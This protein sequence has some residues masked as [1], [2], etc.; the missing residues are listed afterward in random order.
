MS[1][2][3]SD[4]S[5]GF[6]V[7]VTGPD[8]V[9]LQMQQLLPEVRAALE[10]VIRKSADQ[11]LGEA[12][13]LASGD[14]VQ[15]RSGRYLASLESRV[16]STPDSVFGYVWSD[17]PGLAAVF[18]FGG[19]QA[20]REILPNVAQALRFMGTTGMVF[21]EIVHRPSVTYEAK[22]IIH[23]AFDDQMTAVETQIGDALVTG[24]ERSGLGHD[25]QSGAASIAFEGH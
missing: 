8:K 6:D 21:A 9:V 15:V 20:P 17:D 19:V 23:A 14:V 4:F 18:E 5:M 25:I 2:M 12:R 7:K 10:I 11:I 3:T 24:L 16:R 22:P 13:A 1:G